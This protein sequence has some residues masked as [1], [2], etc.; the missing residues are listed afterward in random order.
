LA[1]VRID[2]RDIYLGRYN[3]PESREK[4]WRIVS[5]LKLTGTVPR[6]APKPAVA[7][8]TPAGETRLAIDELLDAFD[9]HGE[10]HYRH[11][12]GTP[13]GEMANFKH[14]LRPLRQ[15]YGSTAAEDF[16][17][18]KL[19]L[20]RQRM[21]D[22]GLSRGVINARIKR[23]VMVFAFGVENEL[24]PKDA[25]LALREVK[26]LARG[27]TPAR[28]T[29][30]VK[31]V[32]DEHVN[33]VLP[34]VAPQVRAMVELQRR[35]GMRS[36]EV[37]SM[38]TGDIDRTVKVW[39]YAPRRHKNEHHDHQRS[40]FLG[41]AAQAILKPWLKADPD[42]FL[43][44]PGEAREQR[45]AD[46][47]AH[48]KS[49]VQPSQH[50]RRK[51]DAKR[52]PGVRYTTHTYYFAIRRGCQRAFPHPTLSRVPRKKLT[53]EQRKELAAWCPPESWHPHQVRHTVATRIRRDYGVDA[54][55]VTLGHS[56]LEAAQIYAEK[57]HQRAAQIMAEIG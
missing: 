7:A 21:I 1:V 13:T 10:L 33:A 24:L 42:A 48:R 4:Y 5:E 25:A 35:T 29:E 32:P 53:S 55:A 2:G 50:N 23:I 22:S 3:S 44:S 57:D 43:F 45:F 15:L 37:T 16:G 36:G 56:S 52:R 31:P 27:R 19:K 11:P 12:D 34:H 41:P 14:A 6:T 49:K 54:A 28:E 17:P 26:S 30:P 8:T 47:R 39:C 20:V 9:R 40:I 51:A 38:R 18:L 46:M